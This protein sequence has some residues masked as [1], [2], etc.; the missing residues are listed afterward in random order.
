[1]QKK[2]ITIADIVRIFGECEMQDERGIWMPVNKD[3]K[4][5]NYDVK[6][7]FPKDLKYGHKGE[8]VIRK[9]LEEETL[10]VKTERDKW[11][12]TGNVAIE[13]RCRGKLSGISTTEAK[14]WFCLLDEQNEGETIYDSAGFFMPVRK[15]KEK[16]R[17]MRD[18]G[19]LQTRI[20][21]DDNAS[22]IALLPIRELFI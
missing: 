4:N 6:V 12:E 7:N 19:K 5:K 13:Y 9:M 11:K 21:G 20:G 17:K 1:M 22:Q 15:L 3:W 10:E 8:E 14:Y 2:P 18:E 16:L